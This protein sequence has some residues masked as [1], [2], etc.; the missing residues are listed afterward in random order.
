MKKIENYEHPTSKQIDLSL[1][2]VLCTSFN[3][4]AGGDG[5]IPGYG[6]ENFEW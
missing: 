5:N 3:A 4:G 1:E 2:G 6:E